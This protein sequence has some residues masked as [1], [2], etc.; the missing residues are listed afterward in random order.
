MD[1][2]KTAQQIV[3]RN[4]PSPALLNDT[5]RL[6][7][8]D[9]WAGQPAAKK[10]HKGLRRA[11][12]S[13]GALAAAFAVMIGV[14]AL[15]PAFAESLPVLGGIFRQVNHYGAGNLHDTQ[16]N[17]QNY[18]QPLATPAATPG[19]EP[20]E[21]APEEVTETLKAEPVLTQDV[22]PSQEGEQAVHI[23][24]EEAYYDGYFLYAGLRL[25]LDEAYP[26]SYTAFYDKQV[27]GY[28]TVIDGEGCYGWNEKGGRGMDTPGFASLDRGE[29]TR[30]SGREYIYQRACLLPEQ[31]WN[32][33]SLDVELRYKGFIAGDRSGELPEYVTA[34]STDFSLNFTAQRNDAPIKQIDCGGISMG[35]VEMVSAIATPAATLFVMDYDASYDNPASGACFSDGYS[36]GYQGECLPQDLGNGRIHDVFVCGGLREGEDRQV[37]ATFFDK[38]GSQQMEAVFLMDFNAGTIELASPEDVPDH[39]NYAWYD[40]DET[41]HDLFGGDY[42]GEMYLGSFTVESGAGYWQVLGPAEDYRPLKMEAYHDGVLVAEGESEASNSGR[43]VNPDGSYSVYNG[44]FW[45]KL[46]PGVPVDVKVTDA[47]TGEVLVEKTITMHMENW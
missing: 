26:E 24:V 43:V 15:F 27:P 8:E 22:S 1:L 41:A 40:M 6:M 39:P 23:T 14:N 29:W 25:E 32:K 21:S 3:N 33:D 34:N 35:G 16:E 30:V 37:F 17:I 19:A 10:K 7:R 4:A 18:A 20:V 11:A 46:D 44:H 42:T 28:D 36:L 45:A 31:H 13:T 5:L 38:N 12:F 47:S 2:Q 9:Q